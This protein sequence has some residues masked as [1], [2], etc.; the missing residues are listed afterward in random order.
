MTVPD[1]PDDSVMKLLDRFT[2]ECQRWLRYQVRSGII[3]LEYCEPIP[4]GAPSCIAQ[5]VHRYEVDN[6]D[7]ALRIIQAKSLEVALR[8]YKP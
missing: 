5:R 1:M 7:L 6:E 2:E 8:N 3:L 4:E